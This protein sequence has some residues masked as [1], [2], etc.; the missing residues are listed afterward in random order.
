MFKDIFILAKENQGASNPIV[1]A[2]LYIYCPAAAHWYLRNSPVQ[3]IFDITWKAF[4]DYAGDRTMVECLTK[5][6]L[7]TV[8]PE[9]KEY[10]NQVDQFRRLHPD[11]QAPETTRFFRTGER[12]NLFGLQTRLHNLGGSWGSLLEYTRVWAFLMRDWKTN[13]QMPLGAHISRRFKKFIVLLSAPTDR[14]NTQVKFPVWGWEVTNGSSRNIYLGV[15]VSG[16]MQD[17]LRFSLVN[18]S[19]PADGDGWPDGKHPHLFALDRVTGGA[20]EMNL[21][22]SQEY[23]VSAVSSIYKAARIGPNPPLGAFQNYFQCL[24]CGYGKIC[25][26]DTHNANYSAVLEQLLRAD[27]RERFFLSQSWE[28]ESEYDSSMDEAT[29]QS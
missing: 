10:I 28:D 21:V 3:D 13:M 12:D 5:Y 15:L 16:G 1:T 8:I 22:V 9:L 23:A 18:N 7:S 26:G 24:S 6:D 29:D 27:E 17:A 2:L 14:G 19:E 11:V 25:F 20:E 4:E